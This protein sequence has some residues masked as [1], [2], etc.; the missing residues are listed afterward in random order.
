MNFYSYFPQL[1]YDLGKINYGDGRVILFSICDF[2]EMRRR[3]GRT[4]DRCK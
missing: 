4:F 1:I 2:P 3:G